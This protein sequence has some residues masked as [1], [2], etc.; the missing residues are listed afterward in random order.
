GPGVSNIRNPSQAADA[1]R[2][3]LDL[4]RSLNR[5]ALRRDPHDAGVEGAIESLELAF[6][7][8]NDM[9]RVL[10]ISAES[11]ATR[12][13]YGIGEQA[14]DAFGRQ[15]LLA[16]RFVEAGVR[17]VEARSGRWAHH[18][19]LPTALRKKAQSI[20]KPVAGLLRDLQ[21][22]GLLN[23]TLVLWGGEFGRTPYGQG[24]DG[25]DHNHR[26]F[27]MWMAG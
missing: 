14:T 11:A 21:A 4:V 9:P 12:A 5:E 27:T 26:G 8:Q 25:R 16:R 10:D 15:C 18:K 22:R 1:Q 6:R 19:T 3:Q 23:Q 24:G 17:F 13:L 20:D 2:M 7:M